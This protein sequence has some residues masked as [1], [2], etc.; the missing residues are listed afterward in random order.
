MMDSIGM[1]FSLPIE[2]EPA[3]MER[4]DLNQRAVGP[5]TLV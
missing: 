4:I 5:E 3:A 1:V 2:D